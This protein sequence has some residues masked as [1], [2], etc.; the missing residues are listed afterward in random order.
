[1]DRVFKFRK[2]NWLQMRVYLTILNN[3]ERVNQYLPG[4]NGMCLDNIVQYVTV[5][6][7]LKWID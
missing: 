6:P 1:M 7:G 4:I 5:G 2:H 3:D